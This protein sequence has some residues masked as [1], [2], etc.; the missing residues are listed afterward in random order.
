MGSI[1]RALLA[2]V[3]SAT[4]LVLVP[5]AA[6]AGT[7]AHDR[8]VD[9][10]PPGFTPNVLDGEV[11]AIAEVGNKIVLGGTFTQVQNASGGPVLTRNRLLAFDKNTGLVDTAFNP[12]PDRTVRTLVASPDGGS[13][14]VGG[15]FNVIGG[16]SAFKLARLD[17]NTGAKITTFNPGNI[18]ALVYDA[19]LVSGRLYVAGQFSTVKGSPRHMLAA[20][21]PTTA[22][23]LPDINVTFAGTHRGGTTHVFKIGVTP[24][25][26]KLIAIG[27]FRTVNGLDRVQAVMLDLTTSPATVANWRTIRYE[28]DCAGGFEYYVRDIDV[29][30]DGSYFVIVTTG[31]YGSGPPTL[32]D[33]AARWESSA[34][35]T[36]C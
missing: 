32:C 6:S 36:S 29:S 19:K 34:T 12:S 14:Y 25:R 20:L 8:V 35:G 21:D 13:V 7:T 11:F 5:G 2:V 27:N 23:V 17:I 4:A 30:P 3:I 18:D 33:T 22:N 1:C 16:V 31:A 28:P 10:F 15:Q 26:S 24:D 9:D